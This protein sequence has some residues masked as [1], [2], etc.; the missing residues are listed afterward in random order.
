METEGDSIVFRGEIQGEFPESSLPTLMELELKP[1]AQVIF[2]KND[3]DKRWVNG[4]LGTVSGIDSGNGHIYVITEEG[5][6]MDV[7]REVWSNV[8]YTYNEHEK[9]I[10]EEELGIFRQF[11]LRLAWASPFTKA[12]D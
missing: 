12:R 3:P 10:E 5:E 11:P 1:G 8:R 2:V 4:T 9:K 7:T 6:E